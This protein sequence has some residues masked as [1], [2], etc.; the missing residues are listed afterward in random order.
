M[1][2]AYYFEFLLREYLTHGQLNAMGSLKS[3]LCKKRRMHRFLCHHPLFQ[4]VRSACKPGC[5]YNL[6]SVLHQSS[7]RCGAIPQTD[8]RIFCIETRRLAWNSPPHLYISPMQH[9][10][11][12]GICSSL[13]YV[14]NNYQVGI[15]HKPAQA[16]SNQRKVLYSAR[17]RLKNRLYSGQETLFESFGILSAVYG[18]S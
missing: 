10:L 16:D 13:H 9:Y 7:R 2:L 4:R 8:D 1:V 18:K 12:V 17:V 14:T 15:Y 3:L 5:S 11:D 6:G